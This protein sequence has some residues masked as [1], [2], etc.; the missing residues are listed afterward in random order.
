MNKV[1]YACVTVSVF[2]LLGAG[3]TEGPFIP[4]IVP[5]SHPPLVACMQ[6]V[7]E[8][9]DGSYVGRTG[10]RCEFAPCPVN[11]PVPFKSCTGPGDPMCPLGTQCIRACGPPVVKEDGVG[12]H[13]DYYCE[14]DAIANKP[15]N[16]PI[17]LSSNTNIA[18]PKGEV[19]VKEIRIGMQIWSLNKMGKKIVSHVIHVSQTPA[20]VNHRVV[21]LVLT[22][23]RE[24]WVSSNH[25]T[26]SGLPVGALR[27][28]DAY[29]GVRVLS[30]EL[31][32][33]NDS[34]T[35]DLL[36]D[37]E[38]GLYWANGILLE[39]TLKK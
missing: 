34:A 6:E 28:G 13:P 30:T 33:Y 19:N 1:C 29:D 39:S 20:P 32:P 10:P 12:P 21:H 7:K 31:I 16:C 15:R 5:P 26:T 11:E 18:T 35:Y 27:A 3:C 22:D 2:L 23:K 4:P 17:C 9:P 25:P 38:T 14:G 24:V 36:P 8:C 37:S